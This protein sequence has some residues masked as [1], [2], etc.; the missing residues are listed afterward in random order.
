MPVRFQS[1]DERGQSPCEGRI[2]RLD[3]TDFQDARRETLDANETRDVRQ[4]ANWRIA[5]LT[6]GRMN[7]RTRRETL[8]VGRETGR[9]TRDV[10]RDSFANSFA[11]SIRQFINSTIQRF[12]N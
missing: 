12:N 5:E 11:Y 7:K 9:E 2:V 8:D 3:A 10:R 6:N 1:K 4:L